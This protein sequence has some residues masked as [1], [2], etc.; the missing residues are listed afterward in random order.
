M[1]QIFHRSANVAA[2]ASIVGVA[3]IAGSLLALALGMT[4][5]DFVSEV[6]VAHEQPVPFS[7]Q[8]H[9]AGLGI[10]CRYCHT[11]VETSP[12]AGIPPSATCMNCHSQIWAGAPM[13]EPVR[14]SFRNDEPLIWRRVHNLQ[15][16]V[17]FDH[18]IHLAKG[19]G[20][21]SCHGRVDQMPLMWKEHPMSMAWCL[22]CHRNPE[23]HVRPRSE[24]FNMEWTAPN[25]AELGAQLVKEY[26]I[27]KVTYCSACHY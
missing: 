18:S 20:C 23:R 6:G 26:R 3:L 15:D 8:H 19:I 2:K 10:D 7:H 25:Q 11:S 1:A 12:F 14:A 17:Q 21:V 13:L 5:S 22:D 4:R 9:V 16:F 27:R 24:I